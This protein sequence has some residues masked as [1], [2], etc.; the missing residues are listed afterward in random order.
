MLESGILLGLHPDNTILVLTAE[1]VRLSLAQEDKDDG[2]VETTLHEE[3][4]ASMFIQQG[5]DI[6][7]AR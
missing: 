6:E 5:I 2:E 7:D 1:M 3:V 4:T